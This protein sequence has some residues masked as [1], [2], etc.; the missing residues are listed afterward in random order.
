MD[1]PPESLK[2]SIVARTYDEVAD[3][4]AA[5]ERPGQEW[6]RMRWLE[7]ILRA[8]PAGADVLELGCGNGIPATRR[9]AEQH[10]VTGV[11]ISSVQADKARR[12]VPA[13]TVLVGDVATCRFDASSFDAIVALYVIDHI[14][15]ETHAA[16]FGRMAAWLRPGGQLLFTVE[17]YDEPGGIRGWLGHPMYF[18]QYA[19]DETTRI[20]N[21]AGFTIVE[22]A[23]ENQIEG[24]RAVEFLWT[25]ARR[26]P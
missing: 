21:E 1:D 18:S 19:P 17:P 4:Y 23:V 9:I 14:P 8:L 3:L 25:L 15:R 2:A 16:L 22:Q 12:N 6:P 20:V 11:E 10:A 26:T 24:D 7:K 5:L 13:A